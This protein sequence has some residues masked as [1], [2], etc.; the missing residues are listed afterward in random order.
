M[1]R[2][3]SIS[4]LLFSERFSDVVFVFVCGD[5]DGII[6]SPAATRGGCSGKERKGIPIVLLIGS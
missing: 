4:S 3:P 6:R 2:R 5:G 1:E